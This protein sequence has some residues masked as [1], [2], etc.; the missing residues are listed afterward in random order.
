MDFILNTKK[1]ELLSAPSQ[2]THTGPGRTLSA[3]HTHPFQ[4]LRAGVELRCTALAQDKN[5]G[6]HPGTTKV[7]L[8]EK[9][10]PSSSFSLPPTQ[11]RRQLTPGNFLSWFSDRDSLF[12]LGWIPTPRLQLQQQEPFQPH[13]PPTAMVVISKSSLNNHSHQLMSS[14]SLNSIQL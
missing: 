7:K 11:N 4:D 5:P 13:S 6:S 14:N 9:R 2:H 3:N 12:C 1:M 10:F 8:K